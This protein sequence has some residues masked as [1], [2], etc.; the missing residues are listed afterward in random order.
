MGTRTER[1]ARQFFQRA[2]YTLR[3]ENAALVADFQAANQERDYYGH[4]SWGLP[5]LLELQ[6]A[7]LIF[8]DLLRDPLDMEVTFEEPYLGRRID[9]ALREKGAVRAA[10]EL[11]WWMK[12]PGG[13]ILA[14]AEKLHQLS[15]PL[16]ERYFLVLWTDENTTRLRTMLS[17]WRTRYRSTVGVLSRT[18][19]ATGTQTASA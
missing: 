18:C 4:W 2:V 3:K 6:I 12:D 17:G 7:Y 19:P 16:I 1:V 8:R 11:K 10:I 13:R 9:F 5:V 15:G 14:D